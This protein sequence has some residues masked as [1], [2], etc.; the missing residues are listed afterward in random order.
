MAVEGL[1]PNDAVVVEGKQNVRPDAKVRVITP[2]AP[3]GSAPDAKGAVTNPSDAAAK[4]N[5]TPQALPGPEKDK[6]PLS[7]K[8]DTQAPAA[9]K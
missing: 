3:K 2:G 6:A 1:S 8:S 5:V 7:P 9:A 4:N